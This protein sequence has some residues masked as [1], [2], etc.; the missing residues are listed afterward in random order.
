MFEQPKTPEAKL[1]V[2]I[3]TG[4]LGSGKTTLLNHILT[5]AGNRRIA[6]LVNE[7]GDINIDSQFLI[8]LDE[9]MIELNNGC[10]CCTINNN[11]AEA[12]WRILARREQVDYLVI[13]TTGVADPLPI[14]QTF[15]AS[16]LWSFTRLDA[17]LAVVD[18]EAFTPEHFESTAALRQV[19]YADIVLLNKT[20]LVSDLQIRTLETYVQ[21]IRQNPR[22][23]QI[24]YG[25]VPLSLV[26]DVA[27]QS[28]EASENSPS[29]AHDHSYTHSD[30]LEADGFMAVSFESDRPFKFKQ[31]QEFLDYHLPEGVFRAKGVLW[32]AESPDRHLFQL[33]GKRFSLQDDQ[34]RSQPKNQAVW[35]GRNLNPTQLRQQLSDCLQEVPHE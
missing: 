7:F 25:K 15:L 33:S 4:F 27:L 21:T 18:A 2:T 26:L 13:E 5:Q 9:N 19:A 32:L 14:M 23:L 24:Q 1:P 20:D 6:V 22:I 10:I 34:W 35:I 3:I 17:V 12:V 28:S 11:L 8:A 29:H 31:F 16:E 30:H